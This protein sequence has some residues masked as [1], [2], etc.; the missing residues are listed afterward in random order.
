MKWKIH[1]KNTNQRRNNKDA[2]PV[3]IFLNEFVNK[4]LLCKKTP[5]LV[6]VSGIFYQPFRNNINST[7]L[8]QKIE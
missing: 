6:D 5:G 3:S 1:S 4:Y 7:N 8:F 2:S